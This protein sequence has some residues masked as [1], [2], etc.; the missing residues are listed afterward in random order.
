M[1]N[2]L[3]LN[4]LL[5]FIFNC[6]DRKKKN[7]DKTFFPIFIEIKYTYKI[8][9]PN[10]FYLYV[11]ILLSTF[12]LLCTHPPSE[13]FSSCK[14]DSFVALGKPGSILCLGPSLILKHVCFWVLFVSISL[15]SH[16]TL[17][18]WLLLHLPM[19]SSDKNPQES[20][21]LNTMDIF[22]SVSDLTSKSRWKSQAPFPSWN[23]LSLVSLTHNSAFL[24]S[25][26]GSLSVSFKKGIFLSPLI[27]KYYILKTC[28][29][30][31][32]FY[33]LYSLSVGKSSLCSW[34]H[35]TL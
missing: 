35:C 23:S 18:F 2:H 31:F 29:Y 32:S 20:M 9:Y 15:S 13:V 26:R 11:S 1:W 27:F 7:L 22:Q 34:L 21:S 3:I 8:Y 12:T 19:K 25:L 5:N 14:T 28:S 33:A 4:A 10:H 16:H 17:Q 24:F 30:T 6:I